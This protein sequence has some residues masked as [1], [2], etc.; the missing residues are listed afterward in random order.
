MSDSHSTPAGSS[1]ATDPAAIKAGLPAPPPVTEPSGYRPV[2]GF[3]IAGFATACLFGLLVLV[4]AAVT[5]VKGEPFFYPVWVLLLPAA[6]L[7]LSVVAR[8]QIRGAEGTRAGEGLARAGIWIS[9]LTGLGY[10]VYDRVTGLA[11]TS[12]ANRFLTEIGEE[13][14]FF[15]HLIKG[16][17][18]PTDF[19]TAF[20]L[21]VPP[22]QRGG[23]TP[24]NEGAIVQKHENAV[25]GGPGLLASFR[26]NSFIRLIVTAPPGGVKVEPMG[27]QSWEYE[28]RSY[29][30]RRIYRI[31]T[32]EG[33]FDYSVLVT[34]NEGETAG[35]PRRWF[36][37][38]RALGRP[39]DKAIRLTREGEALQ[40]LRALGHDYLQRWG[41]KLNEGESF[42][43]ATVDK[44]KWDLLQVSPAERAHIKARL[45]AMFASKEQG[46]LLTM[47]FPPGDPATFGEWAITPDNKVQTEHS[48]RLRLEKR[49]DESMFTVEGRIVVETKEP[50]DLEKLR[51]T[52]FEVHWEVRSIDFSRA[53]G[54]GPQKMSK[55]DSN[56]LPPKAP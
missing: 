29:S 24:E 45:Q 38:L 3:A 1:P 9:V 14:G 37:S 36:V 7:I 31:T 51:E 54:A 26:S 2:S 56:T 52:P 30:V 17:T 12:Q 11:V 23:A 41:V 18:N 19:Y 20:L 27:I 48:I 40:L 28:N 8:S 39:T 44:S 6:G 46:H 34:S 13:S 50:I 15:P 10:F 53:G 33:S 49:G 35:E 42:D 16:A 25:D 4:V 32:R 5:L 47:Q 22:T 55:K 21:S 43:L